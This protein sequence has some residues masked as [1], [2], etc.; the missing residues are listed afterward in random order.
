MIAFG[1]A[2][3][4]DQLFQRYAKRGI[5]LAAE[6]DSE[7]VAIASA[8]LNNPAG[9]FRDHKLT[10]GSIFRNYNLIIDRVADRD[11][12][13]ALVLLH[14]DAEIVDGDFCKRL[15]EALVDPDVAIVGC[16]G[17]I[18]VR[19]IAWWE[20]AVTWASFEHR[21]REHGGGQIAGP[22]WDREDLPTYGQTGEVDTIDGFMMGLSPWAVRNLRF[23]ESLGQFHG[24]DFDISLQARAAGKKVVTE[25]IK[26]IHH[27]SL[28]LI[29][30][31][32]GWIEAHK[33]VAEKWEGKMPGV[34]E[35]PGDWKERARRAEAE[36]DAARMLANA[37]ELER[38]ATLEQMDQITGSASWRLTAPLRAL[39]R[40]FGRR[41]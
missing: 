36:A 19:S 39:K 8:G 7:V 33:L 6:P 5:E 14:Q 9:T 22:T 30:D 38:N 24:Y 13:E 4:D 20:G 10:T 29:G 34:G 37:T 27:H 17:A 26:V 15:R 32:G 31:L 2:I 23:D 25:D 41:G 28:D 1:C 35:A 21:Y 3:T 16:A 11:D 40:A 12:L 18:G